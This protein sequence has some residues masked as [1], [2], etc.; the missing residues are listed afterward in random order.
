MIVVTCGLSL[1]YLKDG[2][3][4]E[5]DGILPDGYRVKKGDGVSYM[6]YAMGRMPY[7]WGGDAEEFRLERWL[8]NGI[9]QP[10]SPFKFIAFH[11]RIIFF[12]TPYIY[13]Y[14]DTHTYRVGSSLSQMK[15][16][17]SSFLLCGGISI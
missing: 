12:V 17:I 6:A 16:R 7:I 11:V 4:S 10:E 13:I 2:R 5:M 8:K 15:R 9:F 1:V 14:I 3:C